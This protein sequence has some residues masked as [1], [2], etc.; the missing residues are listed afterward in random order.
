MGSITVQGNKGECSGNI[1]EIASRLPIDA[2]NN[3]LIDLYLTW[4]IRIEGVNRRNGVD[5]EPGTIWSH[6]GNL[7]SSAKQEL[8]SCEFSECQLSY[9]DGDVPVLVFETRKYST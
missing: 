1:R 8:T 9:I 5:G 3:T 4:E 7:V 6:V 2:A